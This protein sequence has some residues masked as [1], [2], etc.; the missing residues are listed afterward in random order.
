MPDSDLKHAHIKRIREVIDPSLTGV[1]VTNPTNFHYNV[2]LGDITNCVTWN[3]FGYNEDV[4][5]AAPEVLASFGGSFTPLKTASTLSVVSTSTQD[6]STGTGALSLVLTGLDG[7]YATQQEVIVLNGITPVVT[8]TTWL[9]INR[10]AIFVSGT[11]DVNVGT[12][13]VTAVT[14]GATQAQLP[15]GQGTT[16]QIIFYTQA[17]YTALADWLFLNAQKI[18]GA[19]PVVTFKGWVY[20]AVSQSKYEVLRLIIDTSA[21]NTIQLTPTQPFVIGEKS[22][23]WL[24]VSTTTNNTVVSGRLSLIECI[25]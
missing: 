10:A 14:G 23:F 6:S 20:S 16:Q 19:D 11:S 24:E 25:N 17:G 3:K 8:T 1:Q 5:T 7:N 2:A 12:I 18:S 21:E 22:C 15:A 9:G 13:G 4:D